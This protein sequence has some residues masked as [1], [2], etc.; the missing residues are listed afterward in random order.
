MLVNMPKHAP[1]NYSPLYFLSSLGAGGLVVTFFM[2][3]YH[4]VPH[5]GQPVPIFEDILLAFLTGGPLMQSMIL[6][7]VVGIALFTLLHYRLLG[8]NLA[9]LRLYR[10]SNAWNQLQTTNAETQ[11]KAVPLTLA[12]SVN[13]A[14][15][16]GLVFVPR[17][18]SVV[19]YLFPFAIIAFMAIGFYSLRLLGSFFGRILTQGG[20]D[21]RANN[22]FAQ[23]LPAF[24]L[25]MV[26][27]GLAAPA[28]L[29]SNMLIVG[30]ALPLATFFMV[31]AALVT[32]VALVLGFY[33]MMQYGTAPE[34]APTLMI[35][36]PI[37]TVLGIA[38]LRLNHGMHVH[39]D[40][41]TIAGENFVLLSRILSLQILFALI[42]LLVLHRQGYYKTYLAQ[43]GQPSPGSYA[44]VCPGVAL[45]VLL[46]FFVNKGLVATG[47]LVKF[48]LAY[49][50]MMMPALFLQALMIWLVFRLQRQHFSGG[51][52]HMTL[53]QGT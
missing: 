33:S 2:Y 39:F 38:M 6:I 35:V 20:F 37:M 1:E 22:S 42:G 45:S 5:S 19:E 53:I 9:A 3:L 52:T 17:L 27:V 13:V 26:A 36:I 48:G 23:L 15:I 16:V 29:S 32:I 4:W 30:I 41:H 50:V 11:L 10:Q 47:V 49:W 14:F 43:N 46:H 12:M 51:S 24:A 8:W 31:A 7:A 18:W 40:L 25:S 44:L 28:A 34:A 21:F